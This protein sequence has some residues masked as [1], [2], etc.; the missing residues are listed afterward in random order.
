MYF[1][2][3]A[4]K[5]YTCLKY[6]TTLSQIILIDVSRNILII[7]F[8]YLPRRNRTFQFFGIRI[9][10]G[11]LRGR[12]LHSWSRGWHIRRTRTRTRTRACCYRG[13][14]ESQHRRNF[15]RA[16]RIINFYYFPQCVQVAPCSSSPSSV[17]R[18]SVIAPVNYI[19]RLC[20]GNHAFPPRRRTKTT[21]ALIIQ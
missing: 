18:S 20:N 12:S 11:R 8:L 10:R 16:A 1:H 4:V 19:F 2:H 17:D 3:L 21:A 14:P 13:A 7:T 5:C 6:G 9:S 15:R